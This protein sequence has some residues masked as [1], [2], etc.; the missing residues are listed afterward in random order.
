MLLFRERMPK[1][2]GGKFGCCAANSQPVPVPAAAARPSSAPPKDRTIQ[3]QDGQAVDLAALSI[4]ALRRLA[5]SM[6]L[7]DEDSLDE[8]LDNCDRPKEGLTELILAHHQKAAKEARRKRRAEAT[9]QREAA[10]EEAAAA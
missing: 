3:L 4:S 8:V 6:Q 7:D 9:A 2:A 1:E 5:K 10:A